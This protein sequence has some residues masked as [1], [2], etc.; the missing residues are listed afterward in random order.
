MTRKEF[1]NSLSSICLG[2]FLDSKKNE[3]VLYL[4]F[5]EDKECIEVGS[6]CN[7]G[8]VV[9]FTVNYDNDFTICENIQNVMD[10]LYNN[11]FTD[12]E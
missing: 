7:A 10:E 11:G 6:V 2:A 8:L 4:D 1:L 12:I 9:D 3:T 5:N